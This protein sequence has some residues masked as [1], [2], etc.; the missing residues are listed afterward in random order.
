[1]A[2]FNFSVPIYAYDQWTGIPGGNP[3]TGFPTG[4]TFSLNAGAAL[5][6]IDV[7]DDDRNPVGD[8]GGLNR[9]DDGYIDVPGDPS[10]SPSTANNDQL[11]SE[12]VTINGT[13]YSAGSQVELEFAFTTTTGESFWVIRIAGQNV[14]ISGPT[15]PEPGTTYEVASSADGQSVPPSNIPCFLSGTL[16][17]TDKGQISIEDLS[18]GDLV[19]TKDLGYQPIRWI[20]RRVL[21]EI[22][23][24]VSANLQP[25]KIHAGA[26]GKGLPS[27]DLLV[28][29]QHRIFVCSKIAQR[30]FDTREVLVAAKSL[31][32]L[33]GV[34][35]AT[36]EGPISY[37]HILL[38]GHHVI[39]S[40]GAPT[41]SL[42]A[43]PEALKSLPTDYLRELWAIFPE[44]V[45]S[46]CA[47]APAAFI[48][49]GRLQ[50]KLV[51]RHVKN[52]REFDNV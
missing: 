15:L 51:S 36:L 14:G 12:D 43:G 25:V 11:L 21:D 7:V 42:L 19:L 6:T 38:D 3:T 16:I 31:L 34:E 4:T 46:K 32:E 52:R 1:M 50:R 28:S 41:E 5:T 45:F 13:T 48:P 30:M 49:K 17:S 39:Y 35:I 29:P 2:A 18:I 40:N 44:L 22:E 10:L 33:P 9:F 24:A 27:T 8:P 20:G 23:L 26:L 37:L 47:V